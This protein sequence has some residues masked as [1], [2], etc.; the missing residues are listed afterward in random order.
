MKTGNFVYSAQLFAAMLWR[1]RVI[2][3][4]IKKNK[5]IAFNNLPK[6]IK[7]RKIK[8][9]AKKKYIFKLVN[10]ILI[11]NHVNECGALYNLQ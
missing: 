4:T 1:P 10:I 11:H 2:F 9:F 5:H 7:N 8:Y 6:N 3:I